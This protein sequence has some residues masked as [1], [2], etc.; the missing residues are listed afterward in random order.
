MCVQNESI[1]RASASTSTD[2]GERRHS[3]PRWRQHSADPIARPSESVSNQSAIRSRGRQVP[4]YSQPLAQ[5]LPVIPT[6]A[7]SH[8]QPFT[9]PLP[10]TPSHSQPPTHSSINWLLQGSCRVASRSGPPSP[11]YVHEAPS[12]TKP[13][14]S[15]DEESPEQ[16]S[17]QVNS[18]HS[19]P[20]HSP[21]YRISSDYH[22]ERATIAM[23]N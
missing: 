13:R 3:P 16:W 20:T 2:H 8:S 7:H 10:A 23:F 9:Q 4:S 17:P 6:A 21:T 18:D 22:C 12:S 1:V 19:S 14:V 11:E 5:P 15:F